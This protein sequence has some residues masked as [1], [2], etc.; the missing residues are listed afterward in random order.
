MESMLNKKSG[1]L[2][3]TELFAD[4]RDIEV[5]AQGGDKRAQL[6]IDVEAYRIRKYVGAYY[7]ALGQ[8]DAVVFTAGVGERGPILRQAAL[9]GLDELGIRLDPRSNEISKTRNAE[10]LISAPDSPVK[11]FVIPTD[12]ELVMTEDT[13]G[14]LQ[15]RYRVHTEFTYSFQSRDYVNR[16]RAEALEAELSKKPRLKDVLAPIPQGR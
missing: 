7:A 13:V 11:V 14:L 4:R 9:E 3:I 16:E 10:T 8:V 15:G 1:V 5:A 2:G 6:A 12:E